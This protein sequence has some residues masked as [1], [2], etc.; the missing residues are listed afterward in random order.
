MQ[1]YCQG[2][3][4]E[5]NSYYRNSFPFHIIINNQLL[6]IIRFIASSSLS[7]VAQRL[8]LTYFSPAPPKIPP[9]VMNTFDLYNTSSLNLYPLSNLAGTFAH[10]NN[11][12]WS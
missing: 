8:T 3:S 11:P 2:T 5:A 10:T 7:T 1:L 4:N 6:I 12:A 9:G